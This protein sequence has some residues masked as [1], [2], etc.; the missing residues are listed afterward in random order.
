MSGIEDRDI[1]SQLQLNNK[2]HIKLMERV[3]EVLHWNL[4]AIFSLCAIEI[5]IWL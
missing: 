1:F 2:I 5:W 4:Y 3:I